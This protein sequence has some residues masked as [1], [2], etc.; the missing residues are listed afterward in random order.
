MCFVCHRPLVVKYYYYYFSLIENSR[1]GSLFSILSLIVI[2]FGGFRRL[3]IL[4]LL[5]VI[6]YL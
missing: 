3:W 6:I 5:I 2:S 4:Q 1:R